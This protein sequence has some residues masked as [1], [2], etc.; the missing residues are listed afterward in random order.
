M[1]RVM[2]LC[3]IVML[4]SCAGIAQGSK[5]E[6][7]PS[8][9]DLKVEVINP[10]AVLLT[11]NKTAENSCSV[12]YSVAGHARSYSYMTMRADAPLEALAPGVT[13]NFRIKDMRT[14]IELTETITMPEAMPY[15]ENNFRMKLNRVYRYKDIYKKLWQQSYSIVSTT[16]KEDVKKWLDA[17]QEYAVYF[18]ISKSKTQEDVTLSPLVLMT[19][20][21]GDVY[22][23]THN[24]HVEPLNFQR[25]WTNA[26]YYTTITETLAYC[27]A[28]DAFKPGTYTF[29][30]YH[31]GQLLGSTK[32]KLE[33]SK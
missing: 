17:S 6:A 10:T 13:Y 19:T 25:T 12:A 4:L 5:Q 32:F 8:I 9:A 1:K 11:W 7:F 2:A 23:A 30:V 33:A 14:G 15:R 27:I 20:P 28:L 18:E 16:T 26:Q 29:D 24:R 22:N 21:T 31:E 3:L